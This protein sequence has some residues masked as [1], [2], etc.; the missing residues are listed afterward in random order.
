MYLWRRKEQEK[1]FRSACRV[2]VSDRLLQKFQRF[3]GENPAN[4]A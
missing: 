2:I 1:W 4:L 3:A